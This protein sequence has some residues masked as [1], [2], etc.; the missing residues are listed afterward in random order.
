MIGRDEIFDLG[1]PDIVLNSTT[2]LETPWQRPERWLIARRRPASS[3][4]ISTGGMSP[5]LLPRA[6]AATLMPCAPPIGGRTCSRFR[7][8]AVRHPPLHLRDARP[9][10]DDGGALQR[11]VEGGPSHGVYTVVA[12][13]GLP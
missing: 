11:L 8:S 1:I 4:S 13:R 5:S 9:L 10:R 7:R 2:R 6:L 3:L 12:R